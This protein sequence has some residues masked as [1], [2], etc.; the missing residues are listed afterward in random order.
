LQES[1]IERSSGDAAV[2]KAAMAALQKAAPFPPL[3]GNRKDPV[4]VQ[5]TFDYNVYG[6]YGFGGGFR[7]F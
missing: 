2:D 5:F 4:D 1:R 6:G 7:Q 3:P